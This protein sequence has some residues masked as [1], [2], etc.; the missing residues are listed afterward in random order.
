VFAEKSDSTKTQ[1]AKTARD[2]D[3]AAD[4][5]RD[6]YEL[7]HINVLIGKRL[8]FYGYETGEKTFFFVGNRSPSLHRETSL[9]KKHFRLSTT[10]RTM[11]KRVPCTC[12]KCAHFGP[13]ADGSALSRLIRQ[14]LICICVGTSWHLLFRG[15]SHPEY[16]KMRCAPQAWLKQNHASVHTDT[17]THIG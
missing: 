12:S 5:F 1:P 2:G 4:P 8:S 3:R 15:S 6:N 10:C 9:P 16:D 7:A 17:A 14:P 13:K 11:A